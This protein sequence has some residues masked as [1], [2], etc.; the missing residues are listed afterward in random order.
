MEYE[1]DYD[2]PQFSNIRQ[3][4]ASAQDWLEAACIIE[5]VKDAPPYRNAHTWEFS[6]HSPTERWEAVISF[7]E[8]PDEQTPVM[9]KATALTL[10]A[11]VKLVYDLWQHY[12]WVVEWEVEWE[13]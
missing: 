9:W 11:A 2:L 8:R 5:K 12:R 7:W 10:P 13:E 6:S 4:R 1:Q 3:H